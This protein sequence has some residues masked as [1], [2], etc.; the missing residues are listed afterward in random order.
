MKPH[1]T[2]EQTFVSNVLIIN[3]WLMTVSWYI[4]E[5]YASIAW[6]LLNQERCSTLL[7]L[8]GYRRQIR[9]SG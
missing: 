9:S 2:P 7:Q 3:T 8:K 4:V 5:G 1:G 6:R